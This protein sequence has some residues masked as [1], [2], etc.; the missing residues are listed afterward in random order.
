MV[1]LQAATCSG[2]SRAPLSRSVL[3]TIAAAARSP[4][5]FNTVE[6]VSGIAST[7]IKMPIPLRGQSDR[8][9]EGSQQD[10]GAP[11]HAGRGEAQKDGSERYGRQLKASRAT[12][13]VRPPNV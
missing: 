12:A 2:S 13:V 9:T 6:Q 5:T 7:A 1:G 4:V 3:A 8:Q 10:E 11:W